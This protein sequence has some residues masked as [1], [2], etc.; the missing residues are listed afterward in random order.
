M[1]CDV[2]RST[3]VLQWCVFYSASHT[4]YCLCMVLSWLVRLKPWAK[5]QEWSYLEEQKYIWFTNFFLVLSTIEDVPKCNF[6]GSAMPKVKPQWTWWLQD[7]GFEV[8]VYSGCNAWAG[9]CCSV[10]ECC[11]C[12]DPLVSMLACPFW[13]RL[14]SWNVPEPFVGCTTS[15]YST[16]CKC[17]KVSQRL[18]PSAVRNIME[19]KLPIF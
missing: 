10:W 2:H 16:L 6:F 7:L 9:R 14:D 13:V 11:S 3:C 8:W 1:I 19:T 12:A 18:L 4:L 17:I 15:Y 5:L